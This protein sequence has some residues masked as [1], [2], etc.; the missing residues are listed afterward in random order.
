MKRVDETGKRHARLLV[1]HEFAE[2][3]REKVRWVCICDCGTQTIV[4]G[5]SL[6][7]NAVRSCGCLRNDTPRRAR[8]RTKNKKALGNALD[9]FD[10]DI[11]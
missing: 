11:L 3:N 5:A 6:R 1:L 2:A 7:G 8:T 10:E 4:A 9:W